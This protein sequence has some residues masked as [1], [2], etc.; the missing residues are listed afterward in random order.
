MGCVTRYIGWEY[1]FYLNVPI[2]VAA[3]VL[4]P[5]VVPESRL[6][7]GR[8]RFDPV[9]A[10]TRHRGAAAARLRDLDRAHPRLGQRADVALPRPAPRPCSS[11]SSSSRRGSEAPLLPL[12]LLRHRSVAGANVVGMLLGGSFYGFLF[13]GTL[14]LQEV[15][16]FSALATGLAWLTTSL[17]SVALAGLSQSLV[18]RFGPAPILALGMALIAGGT[19]WATEVARARRVLGRPGRAAAHR[20]CR[21]R[22]RVHPHLDRRAHR[23][24]PAVT[25]ASR[26]ACSAR[27][28]RSVARSA[29]PIA[30]TVAATRTHTLALSGRDSRPPR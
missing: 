24:R 19:L 18:T 25:R 22:V 7:T 17:T 6:T 13:V 1:I 2:G 11:R 8:R 28:S 26:R 27:P 5:R 4:A 3:F 20:R 23:R 15:L 12:R 10:V 9:G 16:G 21:H 30:S 29:S 14:Y